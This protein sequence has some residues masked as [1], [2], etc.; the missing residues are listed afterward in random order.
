MAGIY[1]RGQS[2]KLGVAFSD[3]DGMPANPTTVVCKVE[4]PD[5]TEQT[6]TTSS[7][8]PI[9]S[10]SAG[11][12]ELIVIADQSGWWIYRWEGNTPSPLGGE[13]PTDEDAFRVLP[14]VF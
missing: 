2:V 1:Q 7:T 10:P 4:K 14:S 13:T 5:R 9:T 11:T 6:Y 3:A 12:F 8:P